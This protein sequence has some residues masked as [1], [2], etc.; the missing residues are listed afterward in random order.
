MA[1]AASADLNAVFPDSE[2]P[3]GALAIIF[4]IVVIDLMG[5]GIIIPLLPFYV[6]E[7]MQHNPMKVTLLFSI[8]SICQFI[9]SPI[10][11]AL[12]DRVGR[13]PV[14]AFSQFGSAA[15]YLLLGLATQFHFA[16]MTVLALVYASRVIDGFSGGNISTAQ[17]YISDVTTPKNRAKGMGMLGAAFGIGFALGPSLGGVLGRIH[18]SI[19][20]YVAVGFSATAA[21]LCLRRLPESRVHK[22][23]DIDAW[24]HPRRFLPLFRNRTLAQLILISFCLMAAFVMME[25]TVG[26]YLNKLFGWKQLGVGL[27]FTYVGVI[28]VGVQGGLIGRLTAKLG[29]WPLAVTGPLLVALGMVGYVLTGFSTVYAVVFGTLMLAGAINATG[30]SLQMPTI[31]SLISKF[32][33]PRE[34][35]VV[36]GL[37]AGLGS[38]ARVIGP[39]IAGAAYPF[40]RN[41]GAVPHGGGDCGGDELVALG[42]PP[43]RS[44]RGIRESLRSTRYS[45]SPCRIGQVIIISTRCADAACAG[46]TRSSRPGHLVQARIPQSERLDQGPHRPPHPWQ[47]LE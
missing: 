32:S 45:S 5:F 36:F 25:S 42:S 20:A 47:S 15:G 33:D 12:S 44:R 4:F 19:P 11:G 16:N 34:Q 40:I 43:I 39:L 28:I 9:G 1:D 35:G 14:L 30:R 17:A 41:T 27:Y 38:M 13:R 37:T 31:A 46:P 22:P 7:D 3:K 2:P 6:R 23:A 8:Y 24:L 26:L 10:L 29:D 18:P 21:I